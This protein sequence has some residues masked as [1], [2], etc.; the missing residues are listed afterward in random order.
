MPNLRERKRTESNGH[1][2]LLVEV[3][4]VDRGRHRGQDDSRHYGAKD[5][6]AQPVSSS[7]YALFHR[8][9]LLSH[10]QTGTLADA[11]RKRREYVGHQVQEQDLQR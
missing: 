2:L 3:E 6:D 11:E 10:R 5:R 7:Q 8:P 1:R 4:E 9:G